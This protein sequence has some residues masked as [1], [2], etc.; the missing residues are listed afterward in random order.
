[1]IQADDTFYF[2]SWYFLPQSALSGN[3]N[4]EL[5]KQWKREGHLIVTAGNVTDYDEVTKKI[6]QISDYLFV[7]KIAYDSYN[8]TQWAID[9]TNKGL[10]LYP[11]S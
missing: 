7:D 8:S 9:C 10:P 4:A 6:L 1:M 11:Y 5:Y 2:K 3:P